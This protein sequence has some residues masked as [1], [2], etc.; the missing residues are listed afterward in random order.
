MQGQRCKLNDLFDLPYPEH[1]VPPNHT[2]RHGL[3]FTGPVVFGASNPYCMDCKGCESNF[4]KCN[5]L[6]KNV[7]VAELSCEREDNKKELL[8]RYG[9]FIAMEFAQDI[10]LQTTEY[11]T[12]QENVATYIHKVWNTLDMVEEYGKP[13]CVSSAGIHDV[14]IKGIQESDYVRNVEFMLKQLTAVCDHIIWLGNTSPK[15]DLYE[16]TRSIMKAWD[17]AVRD[18]V[19]S[20]PKFFRSMSFVDVHDASLTWEHKD[21][22][23]MNRESYQLLGNNLFLLLIQLSDVIY[24]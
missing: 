14:M 21:N 4:L 10:E 18:L 3:D 23:H 17:N 19:A 1:W 5:N 13:L 8:F 24:R 22:V 20:E 11:L 9:G 2:I 15:T 6:M 12:T 7:S 16:Q